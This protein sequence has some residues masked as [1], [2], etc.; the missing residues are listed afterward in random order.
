MGKCMA[1]LTV[2]AMETLQSRQNLSQ[3]LGIGSSKL[4]VKGRKRS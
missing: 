3:S 1:L 4:L 2:D